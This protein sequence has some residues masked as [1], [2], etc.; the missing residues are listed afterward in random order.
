MMSSLTRV[1]PRA[2]VASASGAVRQAGGVLLTE[3]VVVSRLGVELSAA[4]APWRRP[5]A[6]PDP[7]KVLMDLALMLALGGDCL[8]GLIVTH[9]ALAPEPLTHDS[10]DV[11]V[12]LHDASHQIMRPPNR[13]DHVVNRQIPFEGSSCDLLE[14]RS[15]P[16]R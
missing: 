12:S 15:G 7:G 8:A 10:G 11:C 16:P 13:R 5:S 1:L 3:T 4:M 9:A 2:R 6:T 14:R